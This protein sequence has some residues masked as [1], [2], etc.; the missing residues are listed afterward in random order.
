MRSVKYLFKSFIYS[1]TTSIV[2]LGFSHV[3][4]VYGAEEG[5]MDGGAKRRTRDG[6]VVSVT[7]RSEV[8][9]NSD[10]FKA[11]DRVATQHLYLQK[12]CSVKEELAGYQYILDDYQQESG[13]PT[14]YS[15]KETAEQN[16]EVKEDIGYYQWPLSFNDYNIHL[17]ENNEIIGRFTFSFQKFDWPEYQG[18]SETTIYIVSK[19]RGRGFGQEAISGIIQHVVQPAIGKPCTF[20]K[21]RAFPDRLENES[22]SDYLKRTQ[23]ISTG[24]SFHGVFAH[25]NLANYKIDNDYGSIKVHHVGGYGIVHEVLGGDVMMYYPPRP[26]SLNDAGVQVL[27]EISKILRDFLK[28]K[29]EHPSIPEWVKRISP[30]CIQIREILKHKLLYEAKAPTQVHALIAA[31]KKWTEVTGKETSLE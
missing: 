15:T 20:T 26:N 31:C 29:E 17:R 28:I 18:Q 22:V 8:G 3:S 1:L 30:Q 24:A 5:S 4:I 19:Y 23:S 7:A 2:A 11:P 27:I 12:M 13:W 14:G 10:Q 9:N 25:C 16:A 6:S 21:D